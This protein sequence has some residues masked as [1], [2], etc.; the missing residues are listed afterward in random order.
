MNNAVKYSRPGG[1]VA[2][3]AF[4]QDENVVIEVTDTGIGISPEDLPYIWDELYRSETVRE[5]PGSGVGLSLVRLIVERHGGTVA[6]HSQLDQGTTMQ[7]LLPLL[8]AS[9]PP[10]PA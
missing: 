8:P 6:V 5:I 2:I 9:A 3:R 7:V 10:R 4:T 1:R